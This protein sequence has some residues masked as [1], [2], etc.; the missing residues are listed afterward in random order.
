[1]KEKLLNYLLLESDVYKRP[2]RKRSVLLLLCVGAGLI[3]VLDYSIQNG[4]GFL[5]DA[6][7]IIMTVVHI[8]ISIKIWY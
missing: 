1:M 5:K 2:L 3:T 6:Y 7:L 4:F 8:F